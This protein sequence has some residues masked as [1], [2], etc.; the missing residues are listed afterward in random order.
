[1]E[2]ITI[3]P[4][5]GVATCKYDTE[6]ELT[7]DE[8]TNTW[9]NM[10]Q[11][12]MVAK[13]TATPKATSVENQASRSDDETTQDESRSV[14]LNF[15]P[16]MTTVEVD[17]QGPEAGFVTVQ[18][19]EVIIPES[20]DK[21]YADD[22]DLSTYF[23]YNINNKP[24]CP[25][26]SNPTAEKILFRLS[27]PQ[28]VNSGEYIK[29]TAILP[30]IVIDNENTATISVFANQGSSTVTFIPAQEK[31]INMSYKAVIKSTAWQP[32]A[33]PQDHVDLGTGVEW[34]I[35][36]LGATQVHEYGDYYGWGS[37]IPYASSEYFNWPL[38]FHRL[39]GTNKNYQGEDCGTEKD[40]LQ[41]Y[42]VNQKSI[43]GTEWDAAKY[44][45]GEKW[46][47]P[48]KEEFEQLYINCK[49]EWVDDYNSSGISGYLFTS[50]VVGYT[51]KS[52]FFPAA[53]SLV[54][55]SFYAPGTY[56]YYWS[57]TPYIKDE[58]TKYRSRYETSYSL[59]F[60]LKSRTPNID[61]SIVWNNAGYRYYG[62]TI[63]PVWD[64][65]IVTPSSSDITPQES[66][67]GDKY[68]DGKKAVDPENPH[69]GGDWQ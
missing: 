35:C 52:I 17:V 28:T 60:V 50:N 37:L 59:E 2:G 65:N 55:S 68:D 20:Q 31:P 9:I 36:N 3:D 56:G 30:P 64:E 32:K 43:A 27:K 22:K 24:Y 1:G 6:Q 13:A 23:C 14:S 33:L 44:R 29:I 54:G 57:A 62:Y 15:H 66:S 11:A 63:R 51:D 49:K 19:L 40:P 48:T 46:R 18:A 39:G 21:I 67:N 53:G 47:M 42:V 12:Y 10:N 58:S 61:S 16:I 45:L 69:Q 26:A 38:Y 34:A 41:G 25:Q 7:L 8:N 5:T 4:S